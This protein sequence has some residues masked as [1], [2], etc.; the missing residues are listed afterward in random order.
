MTLRGLTIPALA[1]LL[2][3]GLRHEPDSPRHVFL[4]VADHYE[5][6]WAGA[7]AELRIARVDRWLDEYPKSVAGI[8]DSLGRSPQ[9]TFFFPLEKYE[10]DLL[11]RLAQLCHCG[12]GDVEVHLHHDNDSSQQLQ[13]KLEWFKETLHLRHGL[14]RRNATG[15]LTYG[16]VHGNWALDNSRPDGRWCGVNDELSILRILR[17]T[18]CY[19]DFTM[20]SA[21]DCTQT[22]TINSIYYAVDDPKRPRSHDTGIPARVGAAPPDDALLMIQGPLA[23]DW[24][25]R[26]CGLLPRLDN[27]G[28]DAGR[29][30]SAQRFRLWE[31]ANVTVAGR[32][33]W[34]FI[35]LHTHGAKERNADVLLGSP[36]RS[37][38]KSLAR[39]AREHPG[40][41]YYYVTACEMAQL[42]HAAEED[43]RDPAQVLSIVPRPEIADVLHQPS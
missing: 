1:S 3:D 26:K 33:D 7:S 14:L 13:D 34:R 4:C 43:V 15:E 20:P 16:F 40:F 18:G 5:P 36:M 37:L 35:K 11:D 28:L 31:R 29:H 10:P 39:R 27:S 17:K 23:L 24:H 25:S 9:R 32:P 19:A 6:D 2:V 21:P 8:H 22:Q 38:H 41:Y 30:P 12:F 42:V